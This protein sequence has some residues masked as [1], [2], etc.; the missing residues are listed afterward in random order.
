MG[1][2]NGCIAGANQ[3]TAIVAGLWFANSL[4]NVWLSRTEKIKAS[5]LG[6]LILTG[7]VAIIVT[8]IALIA[9]KEKKDG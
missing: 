4:L 9:K 1:P 5:S 8:I 6:E 3:W 7:A 2:I